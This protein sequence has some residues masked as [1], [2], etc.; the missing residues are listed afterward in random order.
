MQNTCITYGISV[1]AST[2]T[3]SSQTPASKSASHHTIRVCRPASSMKNASQINRTCVK[4]SGQR[5]DDGVAPFTTADV[6]SEELTST[7]APSL[8]R[9]LT[10]AEMRAVCFG[11]TASLTCPQSVKGHKRS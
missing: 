4:A 9:Y 11:D 7:T 5:P 3:G 10:Q 2:G 1:P 8:T 6:K